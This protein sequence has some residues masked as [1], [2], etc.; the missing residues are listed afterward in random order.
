MNK[1]TKQYNKNK[2]RKIASSQNNGNYFHIG[3]KMLLPK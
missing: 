1:E 2:I 3:S